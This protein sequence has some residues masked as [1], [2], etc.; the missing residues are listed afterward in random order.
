MAVEHNSSE[1]K[2][3]NVKHSRKTKNSRKRDDEDEYVPLEKIRDVNCFQRSSDTKNIIKNFTRGMLTWA[4]RDRKFTDRVLAQQNVDKEE[5]YSY[6]TENR[7][8]VD[9]ILGLR[10]LWMDQTNRFAKVIRILSNE[11]LRKRNVSHIFNS[12]IRTVFRNLKYRKRL[13]ECIIKPEEFT[14]IKDY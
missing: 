5:F 11:F 3:E 12:K 14:S 8:R 13:L 6:A 10:E 2:S 1:K 4:L 9:T 7:D